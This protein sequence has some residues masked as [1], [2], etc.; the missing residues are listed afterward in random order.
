[1]QEQLK[2]SV[3]AYYAL[4]D[5]LKAFSEQTM[6]LRR[7]RKV[8]ED[9]VVAILKNPEY[10]SVHRIN[11]AG[12]AAGYIRIKRPTTWSKPWSLSQKELQKYLADNPELYKFIVEHK[13]KTLISNDFAIERVIPKPRASAGVVDSEAENESDNE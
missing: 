11:V 4:D 7:A 3:D 8:V 2:A 1:M 6:E 12:A 5:K 13:K 10:S 9:K